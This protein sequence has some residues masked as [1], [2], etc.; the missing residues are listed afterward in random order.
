[1]LRTIP[2]DG[3]LL[4]FDRDTGMGVLADGPETSHLVQLAPRVVQFGITNACNLACGFCSRD[5]HARSTWTIDS[6]FALLADLA[7]AG[8]LEVAFGGGEPLTFKGFPTLVER[9]HRETPLAVSF[10]TNGTRLD[11]AMLDALEDHVAQIRVSIYD[12]EDWRS[13]IARLASRGVCFGV[14][15]LVSPARLPKLEATVLELVS[16]GCRDVLFLGYHGRDASMHLTPAQD[17][18]LARS[19]RVLARACPGVRLALDVCFG[20]RM[21]TLPSAHLGLPRTDCGAG[22]D[23]VVVTSDGHVSPCSFHDVGF[24]IA[25]ARDVLAVFARERSRLGASIDDPG[26]MRAPRDRVRLEVL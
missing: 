18:L 8:T 11:D 6:A 14:N 9:L 4:S 16:L 7:D 5:V 10:T 21:S 20:D 3:A 1:M 19:V 2:L 24:P 25:S 23:F 22:R 12:E 15:V 13:V 17:A 26:C